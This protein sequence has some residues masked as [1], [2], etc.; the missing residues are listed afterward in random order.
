MKHL[1]KAPH[2]HRHPRRWAVLVVSECFRLPTAIGLSSA[3]P[4]S[5]QAA[6]CDLKSF[7]SQTRVLVWGT[8]LM[9]SR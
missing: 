1:H 6:G 7:P 8:M 9:N 5:T 3:R 2:S 4:T